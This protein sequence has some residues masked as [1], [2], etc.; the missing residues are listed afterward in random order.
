MMTAND[1]TNTPR[2]TPLGWIFS[3]LLVGALIGGGVGVMN[4]YLGALIPGFLHVGDLLASFLMIG[5]IAGAAV[6]LLCR[7][8]LLVRFHGAPADRRYAAMLNLGLAFCLIDCVIICGLLGLLV[9]FLHL[10]FF[11]PYSDLAISV[12]ALQ[13]FLIWADAG[14]FIGAALHIIRAGR[15]DEETEEG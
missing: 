12:F 13:N 1:N 9:D 10:T 3:G 7:L 11:E 14:L 4:F 15:L 2:P 5:L 6:A 8:V